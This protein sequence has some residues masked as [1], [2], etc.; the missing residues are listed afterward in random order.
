MCVGVLFGFW[1][2][3]GVKADLS[4][5]IGPLGGI[6]GLYR[7]YIGDILGYILDILG[8]Y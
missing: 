1:G 7:G 3:E 8:L 5:I 6:K 4:F 2:I